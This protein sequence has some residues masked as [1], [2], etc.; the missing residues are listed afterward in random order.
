MDN[1]QSPESRATAQIKTQTWYG[2]QIQ[3]VPIESNR[4]LDPAR[5][6]RWYW[7]KFLIRRGSPIR[8]LLV[9]TSTVALQAT[10]VHLSYYLLPALL[11]QVGLMIFG[12]VVM[13]ELTLILIGL[14]SIGQDQNLAKWL[15]YYTALL[16]AGTLIGII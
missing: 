15:T 12:A 7:S 3:N 9:S 14:V 4:A 16:L 6:N 2:D 11:G 13:M 10:L 5:T 8:Q 1:F